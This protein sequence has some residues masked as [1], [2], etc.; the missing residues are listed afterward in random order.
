MHSTLSRS[1]LSAAIVAMLAAGLAAQ[2]MAPTQ[3]RGTQGEGPF[4]RMVI[5]GI[6]VIDGTGAPP[7]GPIDVVVEQNRIP[8]VASVGFPKVPINR[9]AGRPRAPRRSTAPGST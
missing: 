9:S 8:E 6:T 3:S 2:Q 5:R 7:R 1:V 4:D